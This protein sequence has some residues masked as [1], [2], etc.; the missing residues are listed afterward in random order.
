MFQ[1][2]CYNVMIVSPSDVSNER[3]IVKNVLYKWNELNSRCYNIVFSVLGYDINAHADSGSHPQESLNRQLLK[4]ADLIIA[5]FWTKLGTPTKEYSSGSVEEISK[6]IKEGK[7]ALIYFNNKTFEPKD[8]ERKKQYKKLMKYK[9]SIKNEAF[10][11]EFSSEGE[12]ERVVKDDIQLIANYQL[13]PLLENFKV[14]SMIDRLRDVFEEYDV[15]PKLSDK[16]LKI[17]KEN[18][19]EVPEEYRA[20]L[21]GFDV[22]GLPR[23]MTMFVGKESD[24]GLDFFKSALV[25]WG[26]LNEMLLNQASKD[27]RNLIESNIKVLMS[28]AK[29]DL[30]FLSFFAYYVG[31]CAISIL[32]SKSLPAS[33]SE[34]MFSPESLDHPDEIEEKCMN[35]VLEAFRRLKVN[36]PSVT[37][38]MSEFMESIWEY[39]FLHCKVNRQFENKLRPLKPFCDQIIS[40]ILEKYG[41]YPKTLIMHDLSIWDSS[42]YMDNVAK[43]MKSWKQESQLEATTSNLKIK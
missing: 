23:T 6:H 13:D 21:F 14:N 40:S 27:I 26:K 35:R 25:L 34:I 5:I 32:S 37:G 4:E 38:N 10:Y 7:K 29:I 18:I 43:T 24:E 33:V 3:E 36:S 42:K 1:A 31:R 11:K 15:P 9:E 17:I 2:N 28:S 41:K 8:S 20:R 22:F 12:F 39:S 16:D 30:S 19:E